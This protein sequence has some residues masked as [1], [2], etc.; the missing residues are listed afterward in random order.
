ENIALD[1]TFKRGD[2]ENRFEMKG[3]AYHARVRNAF[4]QISASDPDQYKVIDAGQS[5]EHVGQDIVSAVNQHFGID[6]INAHHDS[7]E[8]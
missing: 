2:S 4:L 1:R 8:H 7:D 5:I 3:E 6:L